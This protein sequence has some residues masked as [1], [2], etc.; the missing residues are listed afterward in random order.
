MYC[1]FTVNC[2]R[3]YSVGILI[4]T[5]RVVCVIRARSYYSCN[6][7]GKS[8]TTTLSSTLVL[9]ARVVAIILLMHTT[10]EYYY[11]RTS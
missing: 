4:T 5:T 3:T 2:Y 11:E 1:V 10:R 9:L 7:W 6:D 8:P